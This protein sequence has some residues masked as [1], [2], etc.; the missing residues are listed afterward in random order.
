MG[1]DDGVV[2][3]VPADGARFFADE[4]AR[5]AGLRAEAVR[6]GCRSVAS[7]TAASAE[8]EALGLLEGPGF[9]SMPPIRSI[10]RIA[11][12]VKTAAVKLSEFFARALCS[13][14]EVRVPAAARASRGPN[15]DKVDPMR[16]TEREINK[17]REARTHSLEEGVAQPSKLLPSAVWPSLA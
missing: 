5:G 11:A 2:L 14:P 8:E 4:A 15:H 12:R 9:D 6:D 16:V 7:E 17:R 13:G 10:N 1:G 3:F